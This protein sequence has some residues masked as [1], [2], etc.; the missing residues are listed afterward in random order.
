MLATLMIPVSAR[1]LGNRFPSEPI[2]MFEFGGTVITGLGL[3]FF[4]VRLPR[5]IV[6]LAATL[7]QFRRHCVLWKR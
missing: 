4:D 7:T 3:L 1:L 5:R 6:R 2:F